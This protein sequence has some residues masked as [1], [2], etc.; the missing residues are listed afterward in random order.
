MRIDEAAP[1][2]P[3]AGFLSRTPQNS[4][5]AF[6]RIPRLDLCWEG[7][8]PP[9]L[10]HNENARHRIDDRIGLSRR[11]YFLATAKL[12]H[13]SFRN[14]CGGKKLRQYRA[15][16]WIIGVRRLRFRYAGRRGSPCR[17]WLAVWSPFPPLASRKEEL[18]LLIFAK[19]VAWWRRPSPVFE[20]AADT[21]RRP[22]PQTCPCGIRETLWNRLESSSRLAF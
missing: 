16:T 12:N 7:S 19:R 4:G 11:A 10:S 14:G 15:S 18:P 1:A 21:P 6:C 22:P 13:F 2:V 17:S 9:A 3:N 5:V 20:R 8:A